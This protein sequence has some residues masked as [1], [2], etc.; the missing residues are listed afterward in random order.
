MVFAFVL[1][2]FACALS[3][4]QEFRINPS[5]YNPFSVP[6]KVAYRRASNSFIRQCWKRSL[7][8]RDRVIQIP[9]AWQ[10]LPTEIC[11]NLASHQSHRW[12]FTPI[13][14][15]YYASSKLTVEIFLIGMPDSKQ[16]NLSQ[17]MRLNENC[18]I[19]WFVYLAS[20]FMNVCS[21]LLTCWHQD[22]GEVFKR[23]P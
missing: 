16:R 15:M 12:I 20:L 23:G 4:T 1:Q 6:R 11:L 17:P 14:A 19:H 22:H 13:E 2:G 18:H 10:E 7:S 21:Y 8:S 3:S 5:I 9:L